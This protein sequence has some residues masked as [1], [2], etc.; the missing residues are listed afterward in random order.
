MISS[1]AVCSTH[2]RHL[3]MQTWVPVLQT[4]VLN[5][6]WSRVIIKMPEARAETRSAVCTNNLLYAKQRLLS[7]LFVHLKQ[8]RRYKKNI[9][10]SKYEALVLISVPQKSRRT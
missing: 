7:I 10:I 5:F 9:L 1:A 6:Y 2:I 8:I 4:C 3:R